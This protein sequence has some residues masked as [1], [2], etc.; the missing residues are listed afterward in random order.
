M[1]FC[2]LTQTTYLS[3][4]LTLNH[5][6]DYHFVFMCFS[7]WSW[8]TFKT[9]WFTFCFRNNLLSFSSD[10]FI[11]FKMGK[12]LGIEFAPLLIPIERRLQTLAVLYYCSEFLFIGFIALLILLYLLLFTKFYFIPLLYLSWFLYDKNVYNKGKCNLMS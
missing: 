8:F 11:D 2:Y 3:I 5:I 10:F 4:C 6:K 12:I 9:K 7:A 1:K